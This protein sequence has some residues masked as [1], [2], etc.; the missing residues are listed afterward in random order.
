MVDENQVLL[1]VTGLQKVWSDQFSLKTVDLLGARG[2]VLGVLGHNGS[3]KTTFFELISGNLDPTSGSTKIC[4][5]PVGPEYWLTKKKVGYLSQTLNFPQ[6]VSGE[7]ILRYVAALRGLDKSK[8]F[9]DGVI[10][11]WGCEAFIRRPVGA[12]S[13]GMEKRIGLALATMHEPEL[14]ILDEPFSGLDLY[15]IRTLH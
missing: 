15:H 6:W 11:E 7:E 4:G 1:E 10:Q 2:Q 8:S 5:E 12:Y 13:H 3:G 14:L 9:L